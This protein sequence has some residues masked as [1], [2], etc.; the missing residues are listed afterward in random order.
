MID[1]MRKSL[2][3]PVLI[4]NVAGASGSTG[5]G[6]VARAAPDGYTMVLG[7]CAANVLNG[8]IFSLWGYYDVWK[9]TDDEG[10]R[11]A[12]ED[13]VSTLASNLERWDTG[14]WSRYDLYPHPVVNVAS[15][16]GRNGFI[17]GTAYTASK[18][19]VLGFSRSL[20]LEVRKVNI[21]VIAICPGSVA[22]S[23]S[24]IARPA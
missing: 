7:N 12:F 20:L 4:E 23:R 13:G 18:H 1:E 17:G 8:A 5:V 19:A 2:G 15:L 3:Q 11:A 6:R 24:E 9:A 16:A 22:T 10:A 14:Y 21:R